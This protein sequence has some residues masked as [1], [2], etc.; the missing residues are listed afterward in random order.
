MSASG[1][2]T[3][4]RYI[5]G[6]ATV[7][8]FVVLLTIIFNFLGAF[9]CAGLAGMMLGS[10]RLSRWHAALLSLIFPAVLFSVLRAGGAELLTK[11]IT[12]LS[13]LC[14]ATFWVIYFLVSAVIRYERK[15][16]DH[17][18]R[19]PGGDPSLAQGLPQQPADRDSLSPVPDP[20][21]DPLTLDVLQGKWSCA[22]ADADSKPQQKV[23]EIEQHKLVLTV[24]DAGGKLRFFSHGEV[25]LT[26]AHTMRLLNGGE[27]S[28]PMSDD[29]LVSI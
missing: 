2:K 22:A 20:R 10:V 24:S 17:S 14:L 8:F 11:Q 9:F 28:L 1:I 4:A 3:A 12:L 23:M 13:V 19:R 6:L 15:G 7:I 21:G 25:T 29:T 26:N 27:V 18:V 16:Q 5:A